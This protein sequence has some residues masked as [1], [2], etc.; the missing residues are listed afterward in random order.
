MTDGAA[1]PFTPPHYSLNRARVVDLPG[2]PMDEGVAGRTAFELLSAKAMIRYALERRGELG[3]PD[4]LA[5]D[6]LMARWEL[7]YLIDGLLSGDEGA[8]RK[9]AEAIVTRI[10]RNLGHVLLA[11]Y[12]GDPVNRAARV[13]WGAEEWERWAAVRHVWLAG[14]LASGCTGPEIARHAGEWLASVGYGGALETTLSPYAGETALIGAARYLPPEAGPCLCC[15]FGQTSVKRGLFTVAGGRIARRKSL[16]RA[17]ALDRPA[18]GSDARRDGEMYAQFVIDAACD[19]L[20]EARR[21]GEA[22]SGRI[23]EIVFSI[24]CYVDG[25]QLLGPGGYATMSLLAPD[26]RLV[27]S[28]AI[29]ARVGRRCRVRLIH[30]GTAAAAVFAGQGGAA[31]IALGSALGVGFPPARADHLLDIEDLSDTR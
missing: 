25:G 21:Q 16:L 22:G 7:P 10:G 12:R 18:P 4:G 6:S 3:L 24:A 19:A 5:S 31:I 11:L 17:A 28:E 30:D 20:E 29:S 26:V 27:L 14:G 1:I 15:D 8:P 2:I 13:D 23:R 9:A